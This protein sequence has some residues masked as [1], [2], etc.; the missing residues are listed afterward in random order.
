MLDVPAGGINMTFKIFL[1]DRV[2]PKY[3]SKVLNGCI[4][5][6]VPVNSPRVE[7]NIQTCTLH[8]RDYLTT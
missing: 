7:Y 5:S 4:I 3:L 8:V 6:G 2:S 1:H